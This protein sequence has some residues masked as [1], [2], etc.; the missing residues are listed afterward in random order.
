M[1][2]GGLQMIKAS[3][4]GATEL[5]SVR[6]E[7][8]D[9][10]VIGGCIAY[11]SGAVLDLAYHEEKPL[12]A[13]VIDGMGGYLG[14][15][16]AAGLVALKLACAQKVLRE[17]QWAELTNDLNR[18]IRKIGEAI[19]M[20]RMDAVF[21]TLI[22]TSD[23]VYAV[24]V[25]DC[26][27]YRLAAGYFVRISVDDRS[28]ISGSGALT[29]ALGMGNKPVLPHHRFFPYSA[30][31]ERYLLCS[32]G[33]YGALDKDELQEQLSRGDALSA[34]GRDLIDLVYGKNPRDNFSFVLAEVDAGSG[35]LDSYG[36]EG[37]VNE[38]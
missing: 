2:I 17:E 14:G 4:F 37:D 18:H 3:L 27:I 19:G 24:N 9:A 10:L 29:Q 38:P 28:T 26:R 30:D 34:I 35:G 33:L 16:E 21:S 23:G 1:G 7:N 13:S 5:G 8:Q 12:M 31:K 36:K 25:G 6:Q 20:P 22:V 11:E 32:D 15:N